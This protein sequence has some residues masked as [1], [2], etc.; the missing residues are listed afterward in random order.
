MRSSG[1]LVKPVRSNGI[2]YSL[3]ASGRIVAEFPDGRREV[4]SFRN[5]EFIA[6]SETTIKDAESALRWIG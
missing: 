1:E 5:G 4:G 2:N 6:H 3:D